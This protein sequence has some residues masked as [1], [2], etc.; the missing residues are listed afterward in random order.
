M[1]SPS[2]PCSP[3]HFPL[4]R[5]PCAYPIRKGAVVPN[6]RLT[7]TIVEKAPAKG[8]RNDLLGRKSPRLWHR[9]KASGSRSY[10]VQY[11]NRDNGR[12]CRTTIGPHGPLLS[13]HQARDRARGLLADALRGADPA[14]DRA[15]RWRAPDLASL[16][17][18]YLKDHAERKKRLTSA[19][20]DQTYI[21][22]FILPTLGGRKVA[23]VG[24]NEI[25]KL[26]NGLAATPYQ[27]N[28]VLSLLLE[29]VQSGDPV[30][31]AFRQSS[32]GG[33]KVP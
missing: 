17:E 3:L 1:G 29:D 31:L 14:A 20:V 33:G 8:A 15:D 13:Y 18:A 12:S 9:V 19:K 22:R 27:A 26:H 4:F 2:A 11:R 7:K 23:E 5:L 30:G 6:V 24:M 10:V 28:R 32:Q 16:C 21:G 25:Q